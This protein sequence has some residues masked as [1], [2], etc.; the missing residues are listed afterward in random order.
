MSIEIAELLTPISA[1]APCGEDMS[2]DDVF[3]RVREA[4]RSDDPTLAQGE[5]QTELKTA[6]W[7]QVVELTTEVLARRSKD[8]QMAVWLG[9]A[10]I[11]R[12]G[13]AGASQ[14]FALL[15]GL[16]E[17]FW[18]DLYPR[19][20]GEDAEER[21]ARLAWFN[22]YAAGALQ[23]TPLSAGP[24]GVNLVQWQQSREMDNLA[25]QNVEAW[26]AAL[27]EGRMTGEAFDK[28]MTDC[29]A[30]HLRGLLDGVNAAQAV[31]GTLKASVDTLLGRDA[32][33]LAAIEEALKRIGQIAAQAAGAN[34]LLQAGEADG[35]GDVQ[36]DGGTDT[37]GG[38]G[39]GKLNLGG[40]ATASKQAALRALGDIASFFKRTEPHS[41]V[42]YLLERAVVWADMP[43]HQWLAEVVR[44][45]ST[46]SSI[47]DRVGIHE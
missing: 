25:R 19:I 16:C 26:Q 6:D 18:A 30:T 14:A 11:E 41:P 3:D 13:L 4:R 21:A 39:G 34:G 7:R 40:D 2:F 38:G 43:L 22:T 29:D 27:D 35:S 12:E 44:D 10:L 33:S 47:K 24:N 45:D 28:A 23:R 1:D 5:W 46:L 20:E 9:E 36:A 31:F 8:L 42:A 17:T 32:P 15:Q 37:G